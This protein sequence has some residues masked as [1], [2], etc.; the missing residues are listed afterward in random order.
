[1]PD[2][3]IN[4]ELRYITIELMKIAARRRKGFPDVAGEFISNVYTLKTML[5]KG[6]SKGATKDAR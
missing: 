3:S 1:M 6:A 4:T 2:E 5:N